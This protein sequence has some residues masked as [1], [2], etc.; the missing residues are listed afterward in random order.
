MEISQAQ[1]TPITC[2]QCGATLTAP[3]WLIVDIHEHPDLLELILLGTLHEF[4]CSS[5]H[6][7]ATRL[8]A[9][10]LLYRH[11]LK[12]P[13]VYSS[14]E[15][16]TP[17]QSRQQS[18][19]LILRLCKRLGE[20]WQTLFSQRGLATVSRPHLRSFAEAELLTMGINPSIPQEIQAD[21]HK[22]S[23]AED[24]YVSTGDAVDVE[25]ALTAWQR[26]I[27]HPAFPRTPQGFQPSALHHT[28][29]S[30]LNR[31]TTTHV[32]EDL[33]QALS[34]LQ[35]SVERTVPDSPYL[36]DRMGSLARGLMALYDLTGDLATAEKGFEKSRASVQLS[37]PDSEHLPGHLQLLLSASKTYYQ[38]TNTVKDLEQ[39]IEAYRKAV[40]LTPPTSS[41]L[42][43]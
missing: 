35:D 15:T 21:Q 12:K 19:D 29:Q 39:V 26:I 23:E 24:R 36:A 4:L 16:T 7:I 8:D 28:G 18:A 13:V 5:C 17:E 40:D 32:E 31:Y 6:L 27:N 22:A 11:E 25:T 14:A 20:D 10:L 43:G 30:L 42:P 34:V 41:D 3:V 2:T 1:M 37:S 33:N 38:R 9:P